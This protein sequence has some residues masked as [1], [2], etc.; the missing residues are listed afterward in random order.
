[1][2]TQGIKLQVC[3]CLQPFVYYDY[4]ELCYFSPFEFKQYNE[5]RSLNSLRGGG[6]CSSKIQDGTIV[7]VK[8]LEK[9]KIPLYFFPHLTHH[10]LNITDYKSTSP[11][12]NK[13]INSI[14]WFHDHQ[15]HFNS[16]CFEDQT[17]RCSYNQIESI[18]ESLLK[19]IPF[20]VK[21]SGAILLSL[22]HIVN[23]LFRIIFTYQIKNTDHQILLEKKNNYQTYLREIKQEIEQQNESFWKT[24]IE[25][26]LQMI[27]TVIT[28]LRTNSDKGKEIAFKVLTELITSFGGMKLSEEFLSAIKEAG[29]FL[30]ETFYDHIEN[31]LEKYQ[32]YYYFENLRW[33]II[34]Y[35][36]NQYP[37]KKI[38]TLLQD[39]YNQYILNSSDW[40]IHYCWINM[41]SDLVSYRPIISK[42]NLQKINPYPN[43]L[44]CNWEELIE[45]K[46][47]QI[48]PYNKQE[49][50]LQLFSYDNKN[51]TQ[52]LQSNLKELKQFQEF[53]IS[54]PLI[55]KNVC[56]VISEKPEIKLW[57]YYL[58]FEFKKNNQ[59][60]TQIDQLISFLSSL[61]ISKQIHFL[62][63]LYEKHVNQ[64]I[65][66]Y[67]EK[68]GAIE[69]L[70]NIKDNQQFSK[71]IVV[72][73]IKDLLRQCLL[74]FSQI[75]YIIFLL[76]QGFKLEY[77]KLKEFSKI[78]SEEYQTKKE[79][80][81]YFESIKSIDQSIK[82]INISQICEKI[83]K[84]HVD[85][86]KD[87]SEN[88]VQLLLFSS[89]Q[90]Y[91]ISS[92]Q[93]Q[94]WSDNLLSLKE[95]FQKAG[96]E[97]LKALNLNKQ[98]IKSIQ[99]NNT[100]VE[101]HFNCKE[102]IKLLKDFH[103][104]SF[105]QCYQKFLVSKEDIK[106]KLANND[107][108]II[109]GQLEFQI[110]IQ[111]VIKQLL[112][113]YQFQ[114]NVFQIKFSLFTN[115]EEKDMIE[116]NENNQLLVNA[117]QI[118]QNQQSTFQQEY[119]NLV[120]E[121]QG[122]H[123]SKSCKKLIQQVF[124]E[125]TRLIQEFNQEEFNLY[126]FNLNDIQARLLEIKIQKQVSKETLD[127]IINGYNI[128]SSALTS[129]IN[130]QKE[131]NKLKKNNQGL[132]TSSFETIDKLQSCLKKQIQ[133]LKNVKD[134]VFLKLM[135][136]K[137]KGE[138]QIT[139]I[140]KL[141][142]YLEEMLNQYEDVSDK[143]SFKELNQTDKMQSTNNNSN[144]QNSQLCLISLNE[145]NNEQLYYKSK[146]LFLFEDCSFFKFDSDNEILS[147]K[148]DQNF[149]IIIKELQEG[150]KDV[151][152]NSI[153]SKFQNKSYKVRE[154]L[155]FN[156]IKMQSKLKE[157]NVKAFCQQCIKEMWISE[158]HVNVRQLIKNK[159]F[160]EQQ[161][162][163]F[164]TNLQSFSSQLESEFK[165]R[166]QRIETLEQQ[167]RLEGK[168]H[169]GEQLN[170]QLKLELQN[171]Q[172]SFENITEMSN[173]LDLNL[174]F[175]KEI[176]KD[177][178]QIKS[179]IEKLYDNL[180]EFGNDLK[181]LR[182]KNFRELLN[183]RK[184]RVLDQ[185]KT[186]SLDQVYIEL[187]TKEYNPQTGD[188][189]PTKQGKE[190]SILISNKEDGKDAEINEFLWVDN[191]KD[192][193]LLRGQAGSGKSKAATKIEETL[194]EMEHIK[195]NWKPIYISLPGLKNPTHNLIKEAL[196]SE[197]YQFDGN[198][199][200]EFKDEIYNGKINCVF[201]LDSYDEMKQ[202]F[203]QENIYKTNR[204]KQEFNIDNPG[205]KIKI[206]ITTR[207]EILNQKGY[208]NQFLAESLDFLKEVEIQPFNQ[209]Q[210]IKYIQEY[211]LLSVKRKIVNCYEHAKQIQGQPKDREEIIEICRKIEDNLF[212]NQQK[213][214][215]QNSDTMLDVYLIDKI[216]EILKTQTCFSSL[217][218]EVF[219]YLRKELN[220]LWSQ[221]KFIKTIE[222]L[223]IKELLQTPFM[224][225][226]IVQVLPPMVNQSFNND[227]LLKNFKQ[228]YMKLK[229]K[230][231]T[232]KQMINFI[233]TL[234][235]IQFNPPIFFEQKEDKLLEQNQEME[236]Q[237]K[238]ILQKMEDKKFFQNYTIAEKL[239]YDKT[240]IIFSRGTIDIGQEDTDLVYQAL[241]MQR[242]KVTDFY[243]SFIN[244]Y[245]QQQLQKWKD[246][247]KAQN[248]EGLIIDIEEFSESL[249]LE[250]TQN[251]QVQIIY[252]PKGKLKMKIQQNQGLTTENWEDQYF[253]NFLG[254]QEYNKILKSCILLTAKGNSYSFLHKSIQEFYVGRY[255][256][257]FLT[258]IFKLDINNDQKLIKESLMNQQTF[259][260]SQPQYQ[261][262]I[263]LIKNNLTFENNQLSNIVSIIQ[264]TKKS[265][266]YICI[267]SNLFFI[268]SLCGTVL[269]NEQLSNITLAKTNLQGIT[270]YQCNLSESKFY[271]VNIDCCNF[272]NS[273]LNG[274][275]WININCQEKPALIVPEKQITALQYSNSQQILVSGTN[276]GQVIFWNLEEYKIIMNKQVNIGEIDQLKFYDNYSLLLCSQIDLITL[277]NIKDL[278]N[279]TLITSLKPEERQLQ[280]D[281]SLTPDF[282]FILYV[283][284]I[285]QD[286][287]KQYCVYVWDIYNQYQKEIEKDE[288]NLNFEIEIAEFSDDEKMLAVGGFE[289]FILFKID[290][291]DKLKE[292]CS[293]QLKDLKVQYIQFQKQENEIAIGEINGDLFLFRLIE[294]TQL[295][296]YKQIKIYQDR[297]TRKLSKDSNYLIL[298]IGQ[299]DC[300]VYK[301]SNIV[302]DNLL[303]EKK[304]LETKIKEII[305]ICFCL[306]KQYFYIAQENKISIKKLLNMNLLEDI[307]ELKQDEVITHILISP[308]GQL[309]VIGHIN[310]EISLWETQS[311]Q[312]INTIIV[313]K[314][315]K[316]QSFSLNNQNLCLIFQNTSKKNFLNTSV[317]D[318]SD[319]GN[320]IL[321]NTF[322]NIQI[323]LSPFEKKNHQVMYSH[324]I[325]QYMKILKIIFNWNEIKNIN[326]NYLS[327]TLYFGYI[328]ESISYQ[329]DSEQVKLVKI[330]N[331]GDPNDIQ[332][333]QCQAKKIF[334]SEVLM[335]IQEVTNLLFFDIKDILHESHAFLIYKEY[336]ICDLIQIFCLD[337]EKLIFAFC[338]CNGTIEIKDYSFI[339]QQFQT[340]KYFDCSSLII[341]NT[342]LIA[343][344]N[345]ILCYDLKTFS[346]INTINSYSYDLNLRQSQDNSILVAYCNK[347]FWIIKFNDKNDATHQMHS[348]KYLSGK[349]QN[350]IFIDNNHFVTILNN[351]DIYIWEIGEQLQI[352]LE[353]QFVF[354]QKFNILNSKNM[355][356][357]QNIKL[358]FIKYKNQKGF[359]KNVLN[360][361]SNTKFHIFDLRNKEETAL[362]SGYYFTFYKNRIPYKQIQ[363]DQLGYQ[364]V[365][366]NQVKLLSNNQTLVFTTKN[367]NIVFYDMISNSK[368]IEFI[369][370][371]FCLS[372]DEK[373][374]IT[375]QNRQILLYDLQSKSLIDKFEGHQSK[376]TSLSISSDNH[377]LISASHNQEIKIW[378]LQYQKQI[379]ESSVHDKLI[380]KVKFSQDG[381]ILFS[382][383]DDG[384]LNIWNIEQNRLE[385]SEK[386]HFNF[387]YN[388][389]EEL[390]V[391]QKDETSNFYTLFD[392][393]FKELKQY[394]CFAKWDRYNTK[395]SVQ[396]NQFILIW[397]LNSLQENPENII[398]TNNDLYNF[399]EDSS[400][401]FQINYDYVTFYSI[402]NQ[403]Q[404]HKMTTNLLNWREICYGVRIDESIKLLCFTSENMLIFKNQLIIVD[405]GCGQQ[406][407]AI[408]FENIQ[409]SNS[410]MPFYE[411][412]CF[413]IFNSQKIICIG[414]QSFI[415][416][417][418]DII[419]YN[420]H[421]KLKQIILDDNNLI[422]QMITS[423]RDVYLSYIFQKSNTIE[424]IK[425]P[426]E[427]CQLFKIK[428]KQDSIILL[429]EFS[430]QEEI[431][432][433]GHSDQTIQIWNVELQIQFYCLDGLN[434][435]ISSLSISPDGSK[436]AVGFDDGTLTLFKFFKQQYSLQ[437]L[438]NQILI[439]K[440]FNIQIE[441]NNT[442]SQEDVKETD[443]D[444]DIVGAISYK[445][446]S[447]QPLIQAKNCIINPDSSI[448][449]NQGKSLIQL[450][451]QKGAL[452]KNSRNKQ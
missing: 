403:E 115:Q 178:K 155:F 239:D 300:E 221:N 38:I 18:I 443:I 172:E 393:H 120:N 156:L 146:I 308:N 22:L 194:W 387:D 313:A 41:I 278:K 30:L 433:S 192:V 306:I 417:K 35:L 285:K 99:L 11:D 226:I 6:F 422:I 95:E 105:I 364:N 320:I 110:H 448:V 441:N 196:E 140:T 396:I 414:N 166:I 410:F 43:N 354:N 134:Y 62:I 233:K 254:D 366:D 251:Q 129:N 372:Q 12:I 13:S 67:E 381:G 246:I 50:K 183:I 304:I 27:S 66:V 145:K 289:K 191:N 70:N 195:P 153:L 295:Q 427:R 397:N 137:F 82:S 88:L 48:V 386:S 273:Q 337:T 283:G 151:L 391:S 80:S 367:K 259:N 310:N 299:Y 378:N 248:Y 240:N 290:E 54:N 390:I 103:K 60:Q 375:S 98:L 341:N 345:N 361:F 309:L 71:K 388:S 431:L 327:E 170:K 45:N 365:I 111:K 114:I 72:E 152:L 167:I 401:I 90:Q 425:Y 29:L 198:Q 256:L 132:F 225:S 276:D 4:Q 180:Q 168:S 271:N 297:G 265:S 147:I 402:K 438:K 3:T 236:T 442:S 175:L 108:Q 212:G 16:I 405:Y 408:F 335:I 10:S 78:L 252:R 15:Q 55:Q 63:Q 380:Q 193:L 232:S 325:H 163:L 343:G 434:Q 291:Q 68:V 138:N 219:I 47:I 76:E 69:N 85:L 44:I 7:D 436:F 294:E 356:S 452:M 385:S 197:Y 109:C 270:F 249:A 121:N 144:S 340:N 255:V 440:N 207:N 413:C 57:N 211:C 117:L 102:L 420:L 73:D 277:W 202:Q 199:I 181:Q 429:L 423:K 330:D 81:K 284:M 64:T 227:Q 34:Q 437:K 83:I 61:E 113:L 267:C 139:S 384:T 75:I 416:T 203:I 319:P 331:S 220:D 451:K 243:E 171:F 101:C 160:I 154:S 432:I 214:N 148:I 118:I 247:G 426:L 179:S 406:L 223:Q 169:F 269:E 36:E 143:E 142:N 336:S 351:I 328:N 149:K 338:Y 358:S 8:I 96:Q 379:Q 206:I 19:V 374:L 53:L 318:V 329:I 39:S 56:K 92:I 404:S 280:Y 421:K 235:K 31:P 209:N 124:S 399:T 135:S 1:M 176:V 200:K 20:Y 407:R 253:D 424:V 159:E 418:I 339:S 112:R 333:I 412:Q 161:K 104:T 33:K 321:L 106:N 116:N 324:W 445:T 315:A 302:K 287:R 213:Q 305:H 281:V 400:Y 312:K 268:L 260:L 344:K 9:I 84:C 382:N 314:S 395:L 264:L 370:E 122:K 415:Q 326:R 275:E 355:V 303:P 439:Q 301:L 201:I 186:Q 216:I 376:I 217:S 231:Q 229:L 352:K 245:H 59:P 128:L 131:E 94:D 150:T 296:L 23:D 52:F 218:K 65:K 444:M 97:F 173:K 368:T 32:I 446:F 447:K 86:M 346:K 369:G 189:I 279:I 127:D 383:S 392:L 182:G 353:K 165:I 79:Y 133:I 187:H 185:I 162:K 411:G 164:S 74:E 332:K 228:N 177:L 49:A 123:L 17:L 359:L 288:Y 286:D 51:L 28:H 126:L 257:R 46:M 204:F 93:T 119:F 282:Q 362:F 215:E 389:K 298:Q 42:S 377:T 77:N 188:Q 205:N 141:D 24:G 224:M 428:G 316:F 349:I 398:R 100:K 234:D 125:Q 350:L 238:L 136:N 241:K 430:C 158:K 21:E 435:S 2:I 311:F 272:N 292:V 184:Y 293:K 14:Q 373:L 37:L 250:M 450:F 58:N 263:K 89:N 242:M 323:N 25:F 244:F 87:V 26:E 371:S 107:Y 360:D 237:Y 342:Q 409:N 190:F 363:L 317:W 334:C 449:D 210:T 258:K 222:N 261:G 419:D 348:L 5:T 307:T 130:I 274:V 230:K 262:M 357:T 40:N 174:I 394:L 347:D 266:E 91:S 322:D 157:E 208:Q